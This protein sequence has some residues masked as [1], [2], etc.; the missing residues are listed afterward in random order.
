[1]PS[2]WTECSM[3]HLIPFYR[4]PVV[5]VEFHGAIEEGSRPFLHSL[6]SL[7]THETVGWAMHFQRADNKHTDTVPAVYRLV[8]EAWL[9]SFRHVVSNGGVH[10]CSATHTL[11]RTHDSR[12]FTGMS[13]V[14]VVDDFGD[15]CGDGQQIAGPT[16][17]GGVKQW[18]WM[19]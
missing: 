15:C 12:P 13:I 5:I 6:Q 1:M 2:Q 10:P 3:S 18:K 4:L 9:L 14:V 17:T 16:R 19:F 11:L 7:C 8:L